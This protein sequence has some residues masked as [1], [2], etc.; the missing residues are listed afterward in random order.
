MYSVSVKKA[1]SAADGNRMANSVNAKL[2]KRQKAVMAE[3]ETLR[4]F[5]QISRVRGDVE[6]ERK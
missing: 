2:A 3:H 6:R 1:R 4:G 5:K